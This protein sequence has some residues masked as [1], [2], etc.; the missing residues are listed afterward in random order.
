[1]IPSSAQRSSPLVFTEADL[2]L[3]QGAVRLSERDGPTILVSDDLHLALLVLAK[4]IR[5]NHVAIALEPSALEE[6][7]QELWSE[8]GGRGDD[9]GSPIEPHAVVA[10]LLAAD[11]R[12]V[13][14][15]ELGAGHVAP[16]GPP[17]VVSME[18]G[19]VQFATIRRYAFAEC[20]IAT[21]LLDA[22]S[23]EHAVGADGANLPSP[24]D[25]LERDGSEDQP[26]EVT[27]FIDHALTRKISVLTG[28]PGTGKTTAVATFLKLLGEH[29]QTV[30]RSFSVAL[31]APTAKAAVRMREAIDHSFGPLGLERFSEE[32]LIAPGSGS[33]HRLLK[34]RPDASVST[35]QLECDFIIVDEVS[36]LELTL[37]D[38]ILRCGERGHIVLVGDPDQLVSVEV[39][40]VLRDLVEAGTTNEGPIASLVTGLTT[41]HR[42][43]RAIRALAAGIN[44]GDLSAVMK[45]FLDFPLELHRSVDA[46]E[47]LPRVIA[48][49]ADIRQA[50]IAGSFEAALELLQS[51][52][53]LCAN[54][55]GPWSVAW[56]REQVRSATFPERGRN[57]SAMLV[58]TPVMVL[59]NEQSP[60]K[61]IAERLSNGDVGV[62]CAAQDGREVFFLP[63]GPLARRRPVHAIDEAVP[64]WSFTI[65]KSQGSEYDRVIV[66]LSPS[67][68]RILSRELLYT[69]ITRAKTSVT[70]IGSDAV[71][72][73]AISRQVQ[74]VSSLTERLIARSRPL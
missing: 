26:S 70:V 21:R 62:V 5:L 47:E 15:E 8:H 49:A 44:E 32:L 55:E 35:T 20:A 46:A 2:L 31:C 39:G 54:R 74:R 14:Q 17:I 67:V 52:V 33:I 51:S 38:Q 42:G 37:L 48:H 59:R 57:E 24:S 66:S 29:A 34:I 18:N 11:P 10:A 9:V 72:R 65:H 60:S 23:A 6:L 40:A 41:S 73:A 16:T 28:G 53:V 45:A 30:G 61:P 63:S 64:A 69:A 13:A 22:A 43:N 7:L 27:R 4:A 58:G 1:M 50:A 19:S 36:M 71:L 3:V 68:N 12:L 25:L 56:W